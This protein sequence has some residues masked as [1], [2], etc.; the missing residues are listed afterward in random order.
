MSSKFKEMGIIWWIDH[1]DSGGAQQ[2]LAC[3]VESM[4]E[5]RLTFITTLTE[6]QS[7][8]W[9]DR[10]KRIPM[11]WNTLNFTWEGVNHSTLSGIKMSM[12]QFSATSF[13]TRVKL[14]VELY[15]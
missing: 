14:L 9:Q 10:R 13:F 4:L 12:E 5:K 7:D 2:D 3:L 11:L 15:M 6:A 1:L 8:H